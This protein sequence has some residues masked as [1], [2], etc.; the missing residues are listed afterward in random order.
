M[1]RIVEPEETTPS[2]ISLSRVEGEL[3]IWGVWGRERKAG[4]D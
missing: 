2:V 3:K 4:L 1:Q